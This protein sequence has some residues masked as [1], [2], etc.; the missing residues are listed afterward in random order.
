MFAEARANHKQGHFAKARELASI[1]FARFQKQPQ[2]EWHWKFK[3][4]SAE[5]DLW[6]GETEKADLLLSQP[7]P[8]IFPKLLPRYQMLRAYV[9]FRKQNIRAARELLARAEEG[10]R[11]LREYELTADIE[12]L[13]APFLTDN[14]QIEATCRKALA[15]AIEHGLRYQQAAAHLNIGMA[16]VGRS[17]FGDALP[18]FQ[19]ASRIAGS[20]GAGMLKISALGN[21]A[22][23]NYNLGESARALQ[24]DLDLLPL[25]KEE[26]LATM[27][28]DSYLDIGNIYLLQK[29]ND[30]AIEN[31]R[32]ALSL[33]RESDSPAA[34]TSISAGIAQALASAGS[35][36]EA[37][38]YNRKGLSAC[39]RDDKNQLAALTLNEALI[40]ARRDQH[41]RALEQYRETVRLGQNAPSVLW[42][43][44]AGLA[45]EQAA[46]G[47]HSSANHSFEQALNI[48]EQNRSEQLVTDYKIT[49]L[50]Q[51]I[52]F[53]QQYVALLISEGENDRALEI[54]DSS[55][56][57]ILTEDLLGESGVR[58]EGLVAEIRKAAE[59]SHATF[60]FY[61]L[62]PRQSY[63]W[64]VRARG[65]ELILLPGQA[66][67]DRDVESYRHFLEQE[68]RD[69]VAAPN[70]V[71]RRLF[72]TLIAPAAISKGSRVVIIPDGSLH[73]LNFETLPVYGS[74]LPSGRGSETDGR[75]SAHYWLE[76]AVVSIA[77]SLSILS[78]RPSP[79]AKIRSLLLI[80]DTITQGT[81][82]APLPQAGLEI[83]RIERQFATHRIV[84]YTGPA[85]TVSA[86]R[87]AHPEQFSSIHFAAH[88]DANEQ[89]PLDSAIILS[90]EH[91]AWKLY[92]RDVADIPLHADLVTISA[93]RG[94]GARALSGEGLVGFAWAFFQAGARNVVTSLWDVSDRSTAD[95][96]DKFYGNIEAGEPYPQALRQAKLAMLQG[97]YHRP[98]NWGAFQ[99][100]SRF[101]TP[102]VALPRSYPTTVESAA[103]NLHH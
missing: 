90:P 22:L 54:A 29:Q 11:R 21:I 89:R 68:K 88:A 14:T 51:L 78:T 67:I 63:L 70:P 55:R 15:T 72:E 97:P 20:I 23:C 91:N 53:Y 12:L 9:L 19:E 73:N 98:Y 69:P 92:A 10:S 43:A 84:A 24:T 99:L 75:G 86:Y 27:L 94:A 34:F 42:Q 93:C 17:H 52:R 85:A 18:E 40:S 44:Y 79:S 16:L 96:M 35:L 82:F 81:G 103:A 36:Q 50:S 49:F 74:T 100:Y 6:N 3:L 60:L 33:V 95:L 45:L 39:N 61:W 46:I 48:I 28:R 26:G 38:Q 71:G 101:L 30:Q 102:G 1:G 83:E 80:G 31:F 58:R 59:T 66:Q 65:S 77:P 87:A 76:D 37:E 64:V 2:S 7:P 56:A 25:Q 57:S 62:A 4:L 41:Q 5:M 32:R 8:A 47:D 13:P